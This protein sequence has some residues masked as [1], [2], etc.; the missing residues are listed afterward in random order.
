[1]NSNRESPILLG[2]ILTTSFMQLDEFISEHQV[3]ISSHTVVVTFIL[4]RTS[5][6]RN[7]VMERI[8]VAVR[9]WCA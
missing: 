7:E 5:R 2:E 1:M 8:P 9:P 3:S 6:Y 4:W